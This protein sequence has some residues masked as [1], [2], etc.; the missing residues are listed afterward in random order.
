MA[1]PI[2][3]PAVIWTFQESLVID[4]ALAER[5][6]PVGANIGEYAPGA[7]FSLC[8]P[9]DHQ[10][11]LQQGEAVGLAAIQVLEIREPIIQ[12]LVV[13]PWPPP[14]PWSAEPVLGALGA[15]HLVRINANFVGEEFRQFSG[16]WKN[17]RVYAFS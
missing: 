7:L 8:V 4:P 5:D 14:G 15:V 13:N 9:P 2:E 12:I 3:T 10:V 11:S 16:I 17:T 6:K 1:F